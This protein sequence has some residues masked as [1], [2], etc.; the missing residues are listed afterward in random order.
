MDQQAPHD[1][2][3]LARLRQRVK[4][5]ETQLDKQGGD[6]DHF[7]PCE[8]DILAILDASPEAIFLMEPDGTV[9]IANEAMAKRLQLPLEAIKGINAFANYSPELAKKRREYTRQESQPVNPS[10]L[11]TSETN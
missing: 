5:L 6:S 8:H 1:I 4:D 9:I 10:R 3:E 7:R 2:S 11:M